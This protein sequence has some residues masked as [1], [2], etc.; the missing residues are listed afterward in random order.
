MALIYTWESF[1]RLNGGETGAQDMFEKAMIELLRSENP[2]NEVYTTK[3][4]QD[5]GGTDIYVRLEE[6]VEIYHC[7]FILGSMNYY[8][9]SQI[10]DSFS[11][12][13]EPNGVKKL[14]W[15]LCM[16]REM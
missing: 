4:T 5:E 13:M 16:P 3:N 7:K 12:A 2:G 14:R 8:R 10:S 6:G 1:I 9:W 11:R 15:V